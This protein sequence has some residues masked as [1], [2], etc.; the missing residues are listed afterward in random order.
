MPADPTARGEDGVHEA[1]DASVG[2]PFSRALGGTDVAA[3]LAGLDLRIDGVADLMA[4][5]RVEYGGLRIERDVLLAPGPVGHHDG[6]ESAARV[7]V[8][9]RHHA[10]VQPL[11]VH[12]QSDPAGTVTDHHERGERESPTAL[13]TLMEPPTDRF[14]AAPEVWRSSASETVPAATERLP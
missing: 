4:H 7:D 6:A 5:H 12:T 13:V 8:V 2:L 11:V 14:C 10:S 9:V 3:G 1:I